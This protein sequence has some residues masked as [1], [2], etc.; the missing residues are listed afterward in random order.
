[1]SFLSLFG[2]LSQHAKVILL[3]PMTT[4]QVATRVCLHLDG[5]WWQPV[6]RKAKAAHRRH[7]C[8][9]EAAEEIS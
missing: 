2:K 7:E 6:Q 8:G 3:A 5:G 1:M 4:D 9:K